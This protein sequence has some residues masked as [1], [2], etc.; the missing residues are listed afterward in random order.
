MNSSQ[1]LK[2]LEKSDYTGI[3]L[4]HR[5]EGYFENGV[6]YELNQKLFQIH[7][8]YL[9]K[10]ER[11]AFMKLE[12]KSSFSSKRKRSLFKKMN[13][14]QVNLNVNEFKIVDEL[15]KDCLQDSYSESNKSL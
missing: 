2:I 1:R 4:V 3:Y 5:Q 9:M 13:L 6:K 8:P 15:L 14:I 11:E 10:N 12:E 7:E